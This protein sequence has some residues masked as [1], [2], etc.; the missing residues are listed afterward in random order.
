[1]PRRNIV[2]IGL[3]VG[4]IVHRTAYEQLAETIRGQILS[5]ELQPGDRL[6]TELHMAE[7]AGV[8]RSTVREAIRS[9]QE[10]GWL[11]RLSRK[12][13]VV[14]DARTTAP[15]RLSGLEG[16]MT[17][18]RAD[19]VTFRDLYE[20]ALLIDPEVTRLATL[21]ARPGDFEPLAA[22]LAEQAGSLDD[23]VRWMELDNAF[24]I[25]IATIAA[26]IPLLA[27]RRILAD[28]QSPSQW[29]FMR[30]GN[31]LPMAYAFHQRI[32]EKMTAGDEESAAFVAR[33]HVIECRDA[34]LEAGLD[35]NVPTA[36]DDTGEQGPP[37]ADAG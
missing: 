15:H 33:K 7:Q 1:M 36:S 16:D 26:N 25:T 34:W 11:E 17:E 31:A 24:H 32:F 3:S 19:R 10:A 21:R 9:L 6:P 14:R 30:H 29:E 23:H 35:Y 2:P 28:L 12:V 20:A 18:I 22:I 37:G 27:A 13:L 4:P 5:G 8:S